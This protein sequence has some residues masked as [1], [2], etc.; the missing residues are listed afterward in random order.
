MMLYLA[1]A[2][3]ISLVFFLAARWL[4]LGSSSN[5]NSLELILS[6]ESIS[7]RYRPMERLLR[8]SDWEYLSKQPGFTPA[9]IRKIQAQRRAIFRRYM[10]SMNG[11]FASLCL[12]VRSLMVQSA[13]DRPDLGSALAKVRTSYFL[14][15]FKIQFSLLAQAAGI[16]SLHVDIS[17]LTRAL[18][19]IGAQARSLQLS[20][21]PSLA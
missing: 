5:V 3:A 15:V 17:A 18:D 13:V 2:L 9:R 6:G 10:E 14:T 4:T 1:I 8:E 19:E 12:L 20:G 16:Q 7:D 21:D 11:D